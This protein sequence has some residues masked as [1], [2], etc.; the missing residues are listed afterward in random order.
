MSERIKAGEAY[1]LVS[2]DSTELKK[3]LQEVSQEIDATAREISAK[4]KDLAPKIRIDPEP[5]K[6]ALD[7]A[8]ENARKATQNGAGFFD[9]M[10]VTAGDAARAISVALSFIDDAI[11]KTGD[12]FEKASKRIGASSATLSEYAYAASMSGASFND[13]EGAF[14]KFSKVVA[15]ATQGATEAN[16][17]L[18]MVGLTVEELKGLTPDEQFEKLAGAVANIADP[19][20]KAA[21]AMKI[22]GANG[23]NL[24]PL[25]AEG[26]DG[27]Q[28]LRDEARKFGITIDDATAKAGAEYGDAIARAKEATRGFALTLGANFAPAITVSFNALASIIAKINE[29]VRNNRALVESVAFVAASIT[30]GAYA[31]TAYAAVVA[32][33]VPLLKTLA[34]ALK[35]V[36]A[37]AL[38]N[39]W[40]ALAAAVGAVALAFYKM[41]KAKQEANDVPVSTKASETYEAN[42]SARESDREDLKTLEKL[43]KKQELQKLSN[44]EI[45]Q[46]VSIVAKLKSKYGDV[47][48]EVDAVT[49]KITEA[50]DAQRKLNQ[51]MLES[52]KKELD[53]AIQEKKSNLEGNRLERNMAD[54]EMGW[55][56]L[57]TRSRRRG[58]SWSSAAKE[59]WRT[60]DDDKDKKLYL[61]ELDEDFQRKV[62]DRRKSEEAEL[63]K[64]E[65]EKAALDAMEQTGTSEESA[66]TTNLT[67]GDVKS[68]FDSTKDFLDRETDA[69]KS[70]VE[71]QCDQ[72]DKERDRLVKSLRDL[73]DPEGKID[74]SDQTQVDQLLQNSP[75]AKQLSARI[76]Q[77]NQSAD[78]QKKRVVE[79]AQKNEDAKR[80]EK[81]K[82]SLEKTE[83]DFESSAPV[84]EQGDKFENR[85]KKINESFDKYIKQLDDALAE[86]PNDPDLKAR[87]D[88]AIK[89]RDEAV[90]DV[91]KEQRA[92]EDRKTYR[93]NDTVRDMVSRYGSPME[94]FAVAQEGLQNAYQALLDAQQ[95]GD[96]DKIADALAKLG[97]AQDRYDSLADAQQSI[98][99]GMK[100]VGGSFN[101]WQAASLTTR[102]SAEKKL[103]DETRRQTQ[104]LAEIA[105]KTGTAVF[106]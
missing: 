13:V 68:A 66:P 47:G 37:A 77:I 67:E 50:S 28:A 65:A 35:S 10:V 60:F 52:R 59:G 93:L 61:L 49:G 86:S 39:P 32:K 42:Q 64:L 43:R 74:W 27:I 40:L 26:A 51:Q 57:N 79:T 16:A 11:G 92:E 53:A 23:T 12:M 75:A 38:A 69:L 73:M 25:F 36:S 6:K 96:K 19:T 21:A 76:A 82:A 91:Q 30:A 72:I 83:R 94:K 101:A 2:C 98:A 95:S 14:K 84:E 48:I 45:L 22:F 85:I 31:K 18:A 78:A 46:A 62:K 90:G 63:A 56:E 1:V 15:N 3:G 88:A 41:K 97:D 4:E 89:R 33:L 24:L 80:R 103:Y 81:A 100:S 58:E 17:A 7:D 9:H 105:R 70:E 104:Y 55:W 102:A 8:V 87:R 106:V 29:F 54:E 99:Q 44:D 20:L 34:L 71:K 5:V